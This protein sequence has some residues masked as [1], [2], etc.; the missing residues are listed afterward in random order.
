[1]SSGFT[2]NLPNYSKMSKPTLMVNSKRLILTEVRIV[3]FDVVL[4]GM[5][6]MLV[7]D[8]A[9]IQMGALHKD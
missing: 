5:T 6:A 2:N 7:V 4:E 9:C 8:T 3:V 1:M